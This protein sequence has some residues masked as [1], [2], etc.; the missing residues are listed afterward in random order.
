[1]ER[2]G[3]ALAQALRLLRVVDEVRLHKARL[4]AFDRALEAACG[5]NDPAAYFV[6]SKAALLFALLQLV[7][8]S[9]EPGADQ[10]GLPPS[11][12]AELADDAE[13]FLW[14]AADA[15]WAGALGGEGMK[16]SLPCACFYAEIISLVGPVGSQDAAACLA[17][18]A[19]ALRRAGLWSEPHEVL[20]QGG[21]GAWGGSL[22]PG[23]LETS[24]AV[25]RPRHYVYACGKRRWGGLPQSRLA[26]PVTPSCRSCG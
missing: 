5:A 23:V 17:K 2:P 11:E 4:S 24:G 12:A 6:I 19:R 1:M 20:P 9:A 14:L 13:T 16:C 10:R 26:H 15:A 25:R 22:G 7:R 3:A 8:R 21:S 18:L